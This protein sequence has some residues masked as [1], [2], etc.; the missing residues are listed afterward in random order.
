MV[1]KKQSIGTIWGYLGSLKR[2]IFLSPILALIL[3][4]CLHLSLPNKQVS[5]PAISGTY[6]YLLIGVLVTYIFINLL[7][8][9][10]HR[11][12]TR[13]QYFAPFISAVI[14]LVTV[15]DLA[16][17][18]SNFLAL[19]FFP[20]PDM[21][22]NVFVTDWQGLGTSIIYSLRLF[23][24]GVIFGVVIGF[25]IGFGLGWNKKF[26]Y[27]FLPFQKIIGSIP[28][29]AWVSLAIV[30]APTTFSAAAFL[31]ALSVVFSIS[32]MTATGVYNIKKSYFE[33]SRTLGGDRNY[34]IFK[35][36]VPAALPSVFVGLFMA[37]C[38]AFISLIA[39][40]MLGVKAGIGWY[41]EINQS[42]AEY[43]KVY[44]SFILIALTFCGLITLLFFIRDR[45]LVWQKGLIKW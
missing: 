20:N 38:H 1:L 4:I 42:Y 43:Q 9:K 8:I 19:P 45:I 11:I 24:V 31:I 16:T 22:F 33:V 12:H 7:S 26:S 10:F 34:L 5:A 15:W 39:A 25:I 18:K 30:I 35:V 40:E 41:I 17:L 44:A 6:K 13:T 32:V 27:W 23:F 37:F 21:L 36:A 2:F 3:A 28:G 29:L 14:L